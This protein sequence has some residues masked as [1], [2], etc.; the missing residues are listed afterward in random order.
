VRL[1]L[2]FMSIVLAGL[3]SA[4]VV[5]VA[6]EA[7]STAEQ[8]AAPTANELYAL[9]E[10]YRT[11]EGV[12][13]DL[14]K[15]VS[16]YEELAAGGH[17]RSWFRLGK[18]YL[19]MDRNE[20]AMLA[21]E[22]SDRNGYDRAAAELAIGHARSRF[23]SFSDPSR[24]VSRLAELAAAQDDERV[25]FELAEA[26]YAGRGTDRDLEQA[27]EI[28]TRL[29]DV[30]NE[31]ALYRLGEFYR[32]GLLQPPDPVAAIAAY[33]ASVDAGYEKALLKLGELQLSAGLGM[34]ALQSL[35]RAAAQ[36][37]SDAEVVLAIGHFQ[38]AFG[39]GSKPEQGIR[40][41]KRLAEQ[42]N[43]AAAKIVLKLQ[44]QRST[45]IADLDLEAV[46]T[47]VEAV[48]AD[49]DRNATEALARAYR[50]LRRIVPDARAKH[51]RVV[52]ELGEQLRP[53]RFIVEKLYSIYD[54]GA[55]KASRPAM[56][57]LIQAAPDDA[58]LSGMLALRSLDRNSYVYVLQIEMKAAGLYAGRV[59]GDMSTPTLLAN[60]RFCRE[61]GIAET[62]R[63]GPLTRDAVKLIVEG[64]RE[65]R[66]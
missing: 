47:H 21:F 34:Q 49:G 8:P 48:A 58:Y 29:A 23:G 63:D 53:S 46:L 4:S 64:L 2:F 6:Q 27:F 3:S 39:E 24:G 37:L 51:T 57:K 45:R 19:E 61:L 43:F 35:E 32:R 11:G 20:D 12:E 44:E 52:E 9:A 15:A 1:S 36:G 31:R 14:A 65:R 38:G 7:S 60:L 18:L 54:P 40:E 17:A 22:E 42:G 26:Y 28:Y 25:L 33:Q 16:I 50:E 59:S 62:C 30:A 41:L 10:A 5:A 13:R 56:A 66:Q 55:P